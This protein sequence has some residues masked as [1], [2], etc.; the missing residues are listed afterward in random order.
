MYEMQTFER[1]YKY[2]YRRNIVGNGN[3]LVLDCGTQSVRSIIFD[4]KGD[5]LGIEQVKYPKYETKDTNFYEMDADVF[6]DSFVLS[7]ERLWRSKPELMK[8]VKAVTVTSQRSTSV[9]VDKDGKPLRNAISWMDQ[10]KTENNVDFVQKGCS[11]DFKRT[12]TW[13]PNS[14][15][16]VKIIF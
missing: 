2:E 16:T 10:R 12:P 6:W 3:V 4:K 5:L 7:V 15:K 9:F 1:P 8:T 11:G 14:T 13:L